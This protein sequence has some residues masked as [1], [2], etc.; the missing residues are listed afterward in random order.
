MTTQLRWEAPCRSPTMVG[1]A[2]DTTVWSRAAR[3]MPSIR[4]PMTTRTRRWVSGRHG[5]GHEPCAAVSVIASLP[6]P[7]PGAPGGRHGECRRIAWWRMSTEP[8]GRG[9]G[10]G[11]RGPARRYRRFDTDGRWRGTL[12]PHPIDRVRRSPRVHPCTMGSGRPQWPSTIGSVAVLAAACSSNSST[13]DAPP[14][15]PSTTATTVGPAHHGDPDPA[16]QRRHRRHRAGRHQVQGHHRAWPWTP[17]T[18]RTSSSP[19]TA[20]PSWAWTP[21]WPRP[22]PRSWG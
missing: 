17:P 10:Q 2:V 20:R 6:T 9:A 12:G 19:P 8:D 13:L 18:R 21:T 4:A 22:S 7:H 3:N 1:R 16:H 14:A 11:H 15:A 5:L